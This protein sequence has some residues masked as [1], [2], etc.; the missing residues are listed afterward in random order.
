MGKLYEWVLEAGIFARQ[1]SYMYIW[2]HYSLSALDEVKQQVFTV[3]SRGGKTSKAYN[4][5]NLRKHQCWKHIQQ[6]A[7]LQHSEKEQTQVETLHEN[8][9]A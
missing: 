6:Y 2:D 8:S 7:A 9:C 4:T 3:R 1:K 5:S